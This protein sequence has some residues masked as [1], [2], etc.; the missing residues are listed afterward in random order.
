M[1]NPN[2][3]PK[4]EREY[5]LYL[6]HHAAKLSGQPGI[7]KTRE[8]STTLEMYAVA[9]AYYDATL[10]PTKDE[11]MPHIGLLSYD[12]FVTMLAE[13]GFIDAETVDAFIDDEE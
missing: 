3:R 6:A 2:R 9:S 7:V 4:Y 11:D 8:A 13:Q 1:S 10:A 12:G 5:Q